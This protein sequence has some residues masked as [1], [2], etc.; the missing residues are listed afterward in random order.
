MKELQRPDK[1]LITEVATIKSVNEAYIEKDWFITQIIGIVN[2]L[3]SDDR[4]FIFTGGTALSKAHKLINRF[5]EDIDFK[6]LLTDDRKSRKNLSNL[7]NLIINHL[8]DHSYTTLGSK[9]YNNNKSFE[10]QI[11]YPT[12]YNDGS[13]LRNHVKLEITVSDHGLRPVKKQVS[14]LINELAKN[15]DPEVKSIL[16]VDYIENAA[17]KLSALTWR[18]PLDKLQNQPEAREIVRHIHDLAIIC[19]SIKDYKAFKR[20]YKKALKND[21]ENRGLDTSFKKLGTNQKLKEMMKII[22]TQKSYEN[23][24][25]KYVDNMSYET[26]LKKIDFKTAVKQLQ[27][28]VKEFD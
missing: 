26:E 10:L 20:L 24:Y 12:Y 5:S 11:D 21:E 16:C 15:N 4:Q 9:A 14:S 18:I 22:T 3:N 19:P 23:D 8:K 25:K 27:M 28:I 13:N 6:L 2:E 17:D 1:N 7:K